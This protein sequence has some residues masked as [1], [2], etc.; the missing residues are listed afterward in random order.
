MDKSVQENRI[1]PGRYLI[2]EFDFSK[3]RPI[4]LDEYAKTL[5]REINR[6][7]SAFKLDYTEY[8]GQ[9]FSLQTS[10]FIEDDPAG[11]LAKLIESVD[12]VLQ[13]IHDRDEKEHPLWGV[14]G[15][16]SRLLHIIMHSNA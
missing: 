6:G 13:G 10:R 3:A 5:S 14:Q 16:C 4:K 2:L 8:L 7:L 11:N 1:Q 15:V 9:A 12:R